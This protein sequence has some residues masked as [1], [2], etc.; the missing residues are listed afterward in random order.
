M[1]LDMVLLHSLTGTRLN[2]LML[3]FCNQERDISES[4][5]GECC[6]QCMPSGAAS[7]YTDDRSLLYQT[8]L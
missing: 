4:R 8:L 3:Y 1:L 2:A 5:S 7:K 6:N